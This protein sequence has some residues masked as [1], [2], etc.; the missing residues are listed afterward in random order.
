[1]TCRRLWTWPAA[2]FASA[3]RS[4]AAWK[5]WRSSAICAANG[6]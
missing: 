4:A 1:M 6:W 2:W 3:R 5:V